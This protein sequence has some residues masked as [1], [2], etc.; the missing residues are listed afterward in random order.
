M[1][2]NY[3]YRPYTPKRALEDIPCAVCGQRNSELV[4]KENNLNITRCTG[5]GY[6]FVNPRPRMA[7]LKDFYEEYYPDQDGLPESWGGEMSA[8]FASVYGQICASRGG[9]RILDIGSSYGHFLSQFDPAK[10][11]ATGVDPST[12]AIGYCREHYPHIAAHAANFEDMQLEPCSFDV[13]TSFYVLEH[14]FDP[15]AM[16][17]RIHDLLL[18]DGLAIIRIPYTKP[19]FPFARLLGRPLMYAPMHLNDFAPAHFERM[20]RDIGF[21]RIETSIGARRNSSDLVEKLGAAVFST[22]G[23][24]YETV[25]PVGFR[26]PFAGAYTYE[27]QK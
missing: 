2:E 26:F 20:C 5:C 16:M 24:I 12:N 6:V 21:T 10:W 13:I 1:N 11:E 7:D 14:V 4:V 23:Q 25:M 19:F 22:V 9:G 17:Q 3:F 15:R 27:L 18:G 8:I